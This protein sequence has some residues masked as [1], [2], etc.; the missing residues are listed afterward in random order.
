M[1]LRLFYVLSSA[2]V[3][4][5]LAACG[6][7]GGPTSVSSDAVSVVPTA[8][9]VPVAG[10]KDAA[11]D[12]AIWVDSDDP[13]KSLI[14]A[15]DKKTGLI[16]YDLSGAIVYQNSD[17]R[18]NNVDVRAGYPITTDNGNPDTATPTIIVAATNRT[19]K[20]IAVYALNPSTGVLSDI[21]V[22][23]IP[24]NMDDPYGLCLY[25]S[26]V[27]G[28]LYVYANDKDGT[29]SQWQ[30]YD[31]G[32]GQLRYTIQRI[33][34][35]G[36]QTEGCVADDANGVVYIGEENAGVWRYGAEPKDSFNERTSVDK[37]G[38]GNARGGHLSAD[39]EGLA[40]YADTNGNPDAGYLIASSQ[41]NHTFVVYDR[42][43]PH[44]YRG[45]FQIGENES[46]GTDGVQD[47]D[48]IDV[49]SAPLGPAYPAGLLVV[50][51]GE[52][53]DPDGSKVN[54]NFKL[55]SWADVAEALNLD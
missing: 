25:R 41:G 51:D 15:T 30:L 38:L 39:V 50:Q 17:G 53:T 4:L 11:D 22:E 45:T 2:I 20:T 27:N 46:N 40:L 3:A 34:T 10:D 7:E 28:K 9:T 52:N 54:Q 37:T 29:V 35:V 14:I 8:E 24:S 55:V 36:S 47:T 48:G 5:P 32:I 44:A 19:S 42:V 26:A 12:P 1:T 16:V 13:T 43:L 49:I 23:P 6:N 31:N 18:M 21:M 33:W